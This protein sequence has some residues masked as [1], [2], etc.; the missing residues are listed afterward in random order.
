MISLKNSYILLHV[1]Q[2]TSKT[3][4]IG[5]IGEKIAEMF[6]VKHDFTVIDRNFTHKLGEIDLVAK[7][8]EKL[9][10]FEVK[11]IVSRET[12]KKLPRK[13]EKSV[14]QMFHGDSNGHYDVVY[15]NQNDIINDIDIAN[16][17]DIDTPISDIGGNLLAPQGHDKRHDETIETRKIQKPN[18]T[19][20]VYNPYENISRSK[21]AKTLR[22]VQIYLAQK[23]VSRETSWQLDALGVILFNTKDSSDKPKITGNV[24]RIKHI[25]I[26]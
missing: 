8:D 3:Q 7:K 24:T 12:L 9:Y 13:D 2:F 10:F 21:I 17:N 6:L 18:Q 22:T 14:S 23:H 16:L 5:E 25:N 4:K 11:S 20:V 19:N 1:K 15:T 26:N